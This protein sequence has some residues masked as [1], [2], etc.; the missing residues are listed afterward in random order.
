MS[1]ARRQSAPT[2]VLA[3]SF[4]LSRSS[5]TS[6][7]R[8]SFP[9]LPSGEE[10]ATASGSFGVGLFG[11]IWSFWGPF[12][13]S[14]FYKRSVTRAHAERAQTRP[15][16][17]RSRQQGRMGPLPPLPRLLVGA[18]P[19]GSNEAIDREHWTR[20][21]GF[22]HHKS[23]RNTSAARGR[24]CL[25]L[26]RQVHW[27]S[28]AEHHHSAFLRLYRRK[29]ALWWCNRQYPTV[30]DD[31][32]VLISHIIIS[33]DTKKRKKTFFGRCLNESYSLCTYYSFVLFTFDS[34]LT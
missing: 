29:K 1:S 12:W 5:S 19:S 14:S 32:F 23:L 30:R 6:P 7:L 28:F 34:R 33:Y 16:L 4:H 25:A 21:D 26:S 17:R 22:R 13:A 2:L 11:A 10:N 3:A 31:E 8:P 18:V 20:S 9:Q 15:Q 27:L 24:A